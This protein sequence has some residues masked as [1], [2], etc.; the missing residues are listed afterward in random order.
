MKKLILV[1]SVLLQLFGC[2]GVRSSESESQ[3]DK[4]RCDLIPVSECDS[5][6]RCKVDHWMGTCEERWPDSHCGWIQSSKKCEKDPACSWKHFPG[7]CE[8]KP[9]KG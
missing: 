5:Y 1:L 3:S 2:D 9:M 4:H 6:D 7:L 8:G